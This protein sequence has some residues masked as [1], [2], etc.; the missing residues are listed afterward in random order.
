[1][2][3]IKETFGKIK[4][5]VKPLIVKPIIALYTVYLRIILIILYVFIAIFVSSLFQIIGSYKENLELILTIAEFATIGSGTLA[6]LTF[7]FA[8]AKYKTEV[9]SKIV[10]SG[11]YLF[12]STLIFIIGIVLLIGVRLMLENPD[13]ISRYLS[14]FSGAYTILLVMTE[15]FLLLI[16][17]ISLVISPFFFVKGIEELIE[18][19]KM[20]KST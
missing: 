1:M 12:Q 2:N 6:I 9:H 5:I 19:F 18:V 16:A 8:L 4:F 10:K 17:V 7:T 3:K 15:W 11:E 14:V 20:S 13:T